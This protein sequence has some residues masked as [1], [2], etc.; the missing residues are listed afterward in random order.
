MAD[1][2][3]LLFMLPTKLTKKTSILLFARREYATELIFIFSESENCVFFWR[4]RPS[5][6]PIY[7]FFYS[8]NY[9][10]LNSNCSAKCKCILH[11]NCI[12]T[13]FKPMQI[14]TKSYRFTI[15]FAHLFAC[16]LPP[17]CPSTLLFCFNF[18]KCTKGL[19]RYELCE[20]ELICQWRSL[21]KSSN[22]RI[23]HVSMF[24]AIK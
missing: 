11:W 20:Y 17:F 9:G 2:K 7:V 12:F 24:N 8:H 6:L 18:L 1:A 13:C 22:K 16:Y 3:S 4:S 21:H 10:K 19:C 23:Y 15:H 14:N 5:I